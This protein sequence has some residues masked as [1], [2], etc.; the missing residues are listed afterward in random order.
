MARLFRAIAFV[1]DCART[2]GGVAIATLPAAVYYCPRRVAAIEREAPGAAFFFFVHEV[3]HLALGT[4]NERTVDCWAAARFPA[5]SGGLRQ[6]RAAARFVAANTRPD[7]R[8]GTG[9]ERAAR[10]VRCYRNAMPA[11]P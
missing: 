6:I 10:L 5:L 7:S 4:G 2:R 8:Y 9:P 11:H 3:G 1:P